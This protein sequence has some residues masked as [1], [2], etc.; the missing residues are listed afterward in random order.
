MYHSMIIGGFNTWDKW[1]IVPTSRPS[2]VPPTI[3][4]NLID[5]AGANGVIN[6]SYL[7]TGYPI[8]GMREGSQEFMIIHDNLDKNYWVELY[9]DML[10]RLHGRELECVLEDDPNWVYTGTFSLDPLSSQKDYSR[11][12]IKYKLN[13]YKLSPKSVAELHPERFAPIL[14]K[15]G[16][17]DIA[18]LTEVTNY[19]DRM[20][21]V[22]T[23]N[24]SNLNESLPFSFSNEE[25][26][27]RLTSSLEPGIIKDH[28]I[29]FTNF[30]GENNIHLNI[31]AK[32]GETLTLDF[33]NGRL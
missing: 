33:V 2:I 3:K 32:G 11:I 31:S 27:I 7:L 5:V 25:L 14:L 1:H 17:N 19:I 6:A 10:F 22:P 4:E 13:P 21:V 12:T 28:R 15:S 16:Y 23:L 8:Y 30:T 9:S 20:P 18:L 29:I 26:G 24:R